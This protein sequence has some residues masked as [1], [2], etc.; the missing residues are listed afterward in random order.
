MKY[1]G[2]TLIASLLVMA[3][4]AQEKKTYRLINNTGMEAIVSNYG[5]RL[6]S[7]TASNWNGRLQPV[8]KGYKDIK[9][10]LREPALGATLICNDGALKTTLAEKTW[11]V[12]SAD[13]QSVTF[14]YSSFEDEKGFE[15]KMNFSVTYT[16][17]D[18]NALDIHY[19]VTSTVATH[20]T[21]TN[22]IV[23][24]IGGN[25]ARSILKQHL[26]IDSYKTNLFNEDMQL[27]DEQ[28]YI[29]RT[30]L[31]FIQPREIG[32]RINDLKSGYRHAFQL[33]HPGNVQ[34]PAVIIFDA[35]SGR[36]M[37]VYTYE[38]TLKIDTYGKK[39][40]GISFQPLHKGYDEDKVEINATVEPGQVFHTVTVFIFTTE[41]PVMMEQG[42][43]MK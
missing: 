43:A 17:S 35:Q 30:P 9:A 11:D 14:R 15:G 22:G 2:I 28:N 38:P 26:W 10:Y 31:N 34:K 40:K 23:F 16:L 6:M 19:Q 12:V 3:A 4:Q 32:E 25:P 36:A 8:V 21:L 39:S 1:I 13:E 42:T 18:Q 27:T 33:R 7:L 41:V 29:R 37:T 24:N 20:Y 5:A